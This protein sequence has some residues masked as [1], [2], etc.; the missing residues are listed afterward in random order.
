MCE[1]AMYN[2]VQPVFAKLHQKHITCHVMRV[3]SL[4]VSKQIIVRKEFSLWAPIK[5]IIEPPHS[6][7]RTLPCRP[8]PPVIPPPDVHEPLWEL[9]PVLRFQDV[10]GTI[11]LEHDV[12]IWKIS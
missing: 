11:D 10:F 5:A 4:S 7:S 6:S 1:I 2:H 12:E 8:G 3:F 9:D